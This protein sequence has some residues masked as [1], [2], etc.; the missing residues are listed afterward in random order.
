MSDTFKNNK[1]T[2]SSIYD[3][4]NIF[5]LM[6]ALVLLTSCATGQTDDEHGAF[7]E[8]SEDKCSPVDRLSEAD[9]KIILY[10]AKIY[11]DSIRAHVLSRKNKVGIAPKVEIDFTVQDREFSKYYENA[12]MLYLSGD[13]SSDFYRSLITI[14][15]LFTIAEGC[16]PEVK[17]KIVSID[18]LDNNCV[19]AQPLE[20]DQKRTFLFKVKSDWD[21]LTVHMRGLQFRG[22]LSDDKL[23]E[24]DALSNRF[25]DNY[26]NACMLYLKGDISSPEITRSLMTLEEINEDSNKL[27][28]D[29]GR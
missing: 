3:T 13:I 23:K 8:Y 10:E 2:N 24:F 19:M 9:I 18:M 25:N 14:Q 16:Y 21:E 17:K 20:E 27:L 5:L 29:M 6:F 1:D 26:R 4:M 7:A 11:W 15:Q 12:L 22:T 28:H